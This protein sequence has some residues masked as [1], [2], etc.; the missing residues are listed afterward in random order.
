[1]LAASSRCIALPTCAP[2]LMRPSS[3]VRAHPATAQQRADRG[4][5]P[6]PAQTDSKDDTGLAAC[7]VGISSGPEE[8]V[9]GLGN[10]AVVHVVS[11]PAE[12]HSESNPVGIGQ[13]LRRS[14]RL[15][16]R[17][18]ENEVAV[19]GMQGGGCLLSRAKLH[20]PHTANW[21]IVEVINQPV[22]GYRTGRFNHAVRLHVSE[23]PD[24][25]P[26]PPHGSNPDRVPV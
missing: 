19:H 10:E 1:M 6:G 4:N 17:V 13:D 3:R 8:K 7:R 16:T 18:D 15:R 21:Q 11:L 14:Q 9:P 22:Y 25:L 5:Q 2:G 26:G 23:G 24:A 20:N 12:R